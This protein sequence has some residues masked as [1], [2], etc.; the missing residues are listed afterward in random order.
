MLAPSLTQKLIRPLALV[1][2]AGPCALLALSLVVVCLHWHTLAPWNLPVHEDGERTLFN[3]IFF[4]EHATREMPGD[5]LLAMAAGAAVYFALPQP[6]RGR[7]RFDARDRTLTVVAVILAAIIVGA[8][9]LQGGAQMVIENLQQ[10]HTR[11]G[12]P[13]IWGSH[14]RY[15]LLE[16]LPMIMTATALGAAVRALVGRGG[17]AAG[18][19]GVRAGG[20]LIGLYLVATVVFTRSW[21]DLALPFFDTRYLGHEAREIFTHLIMTLPLGLGGAVLL[22]GPFR[23][24][25]PPAPIRLKAF[26][27]PVGLLSLALAMA[28][29]ALIKA[30]ASGAASEGQTDDVVSLVLVH[31]FEH[32]LG[33]ILVP[34]TAAA[35]YGVCRALDRT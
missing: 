26:A 31:F 11:P 1:A 8:A 35:A 25:E 24:A 15:H 23:H 6:A 5:L 3:T 28:S 17:G 13:L 33:Y 22:Q 29:Y 20:F 27:W 4:F 18:R 16:R 21:S 34:F 30:M 7:P 12:A 10:H 32:D 9:T 19:T 14:W 2:V